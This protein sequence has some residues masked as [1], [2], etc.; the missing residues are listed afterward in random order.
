MRAVDYGPQ[1]DHIDVDEDCQG[2][3]EATLADE[4]YQNAYR[5]RL[6]WVLRDHAPAVY[7]EKLSDYPKNHPPIQF[8]VFLEHSV[9]EAWDII[10]EMYGR[11]NTRARLK[12][13][14]EESAEG[15]IID[16]AVERAEKKKLYTVRNP[17]TVKAIE[18]SK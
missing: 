18:R 5:Y 6:T 11:E 2:V 12:E 17:R 10:D 15:A 16:E 9:G 3:M 8:P 14:A 13:L 1:T 7:I 4:E